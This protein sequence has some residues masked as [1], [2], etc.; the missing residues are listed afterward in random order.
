MTVAGG[1]SYGD[2]QEVRDLALA[3]NND[4]KYIKVALDR[5]EQHMSQ[6]RVEWTSREALMIA[7]IDALE[8]KC[9]IQQGSTEG[10]LRSAAV[11]SG[12]LTLIGMFLAVY[13]SLVVR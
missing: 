10:V 7:R 8:R 1:V 9:D 13:I 3:T 11:V 12:V 5:I 6:T 4:L 2:H